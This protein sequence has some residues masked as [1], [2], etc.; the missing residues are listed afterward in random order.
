MEGTARAWEG[1]RHRLLCLP[2]MCAKGEAGGRGEA[3]RKPGGGGGI[4]RAE[5][6]MEG[7]GVRIAPPPAFAQRVWEDVHAAG[8][9]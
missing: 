4:A 5:G 7:G 1:G 3:R 8:S 2:G 6:R 9:A